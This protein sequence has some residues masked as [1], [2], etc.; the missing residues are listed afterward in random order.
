MSARLV[1]E[2]DTTLLEGLAIP[3]IPWLI[4]YNLPFLPP[5]GCS[6]IV[7]LFVLLVF[8]QQGFPTR[9]LRRCHSDTHCR[10]MWWHFY[11][12]MDVQVGHTQGL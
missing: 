5:W 6:P 10:D 2:E 3:D 7:G 4:M 11:A 9:S 12:P 8:L 1:F